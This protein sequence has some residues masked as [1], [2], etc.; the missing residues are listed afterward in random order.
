MFTM[1]RSAR[2]AFGVA[3]IG[4]LAPIALSAQSIWIDPGLG[5][6]LT[7][8]ALKPNLEGEGATLTTSVHFVGIRLSA[9]QNLRLVAEAPFAYGDVKEE[10]DGLPE[11]VEKATLGNPYLGIEWVPS[12]GSP[13]FVELGARAPLASDLFVD[14]TLEEGN[15]GTAIGLLTE[16]GTRAEAFL[17]DIV[18][19][20]AMANYWLRLSE[21]EAAGLA[22]RLRGGPVTWIPT[23]GGDVELLGVYSAQLWYQGAGFSLGGGYVGRGILTDEDASF[24]EATVHQVGGSANLTLGRLV[25]G[26]QFRVPL[27]EED[28][29]DFIAGLNLGLRLN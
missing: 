2:A 7:L 5:D 12:T 27:D 25:P 19:L 10:A 21:G 8:E 4:T 14:E 28:G 13:F 18:P 20:S 9:G 17:P 22:L 6:A 24:D 16:F 29:V 1:I 3:L 15:F 11:G 23:D 26:L